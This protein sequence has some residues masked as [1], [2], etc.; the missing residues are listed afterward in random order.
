MMSQ[1]RVLGSTVAVALL[2]G[3]ATQSTNTVPRPI[4]PQEGPRAS[5][6]TVYSGGMLNR[7]VETTFSVDQWAFV[8]VGHV[9]GDGSIEILYPESP[10]DM[11]PVKGSVKLRARP[12]YSPIDG[13]SRLYRTT[14]YRT[15]GAK[16]D[17][18]DGSGDDFVFAIAS[19]LP[20]NYQAFALG[21]GWDTMSIDDY[22]A[23]WDPRLG[24][25]DFA[26][27]LAPATA[28][29]ISYARAHTSIRYADVASL[30]DC[31]YEDV[32]GFGVPWMGLY[33][34]GGMSWWSPFSPSFLMLSSSY[35]VRGSV[36]NADWDSTNAACGSTLRYATFARS[37]YFPTLTPQLGPTPPTNPR[38]PKTTRA[39]AP[40]K[41][42][43]PRALAYRRR[44]DDDGWGSR[45]HASTSS[46][47]SGTSGPRSFTPMTNTA[48]NSGSNGS[49]TSAPAPSGDRQGNA[50]RTKQ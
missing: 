40:R 20:L 36:F 43:N 3:C 26:D 33:A 44:G 4:A 16:F 2:A 41:P 30:S 12:F 25:R 37:Q 1:M 29:S 19:R 27:E 38:V 22:Y 24:V 34:P 6:Y 8:L 50:P 45:T 46:G 23:S 39:W 7:R 14:A 49:S 21:R 32:G 48:S 11:K 13:M 47:G 17:S 9:A 10:D 28:Y 42:T 15:I 5:V 31:A 35:L 18:Y